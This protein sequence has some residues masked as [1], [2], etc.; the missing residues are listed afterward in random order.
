LEGEYDDRPQEGQSQ[1][2]EE[3]E[4]ENENQQGSLDGDMDVILQH[5]PKE[6]EDKDIGKKEEQFE[7]KTEMKD[8][9]IT[10]EEYGVDKYSW[11]AQSSNDD[12]HSAR[13]DDNALSISNEKE[14]EMK[15]EEMVDEN[16][17]KEEVMEEKEEE[18]EQVGVISGTE[19]F[20]EKE[21]EEEEEMEQDAKGENGSA[22]PPH[23]GEIASPIEPSSPIST[24]L[25][26]DEHSRNELVVLHS[27]K[28][29]LVV[30]D[31][32]YHSVIP[33]AMDLHNNDRFDN[34]KEDAKSE[35]S[36]QEENHDIM[37]HE[38]EKKTIV[39]ET[40]H[41]F[42]PD[43]N[44]RIENPMVNTTIDKSIPN[45][46]DSPDTITET[47]AAS[48]TTTP[49]STS[50]SNLECLQLQQHVQALEK[51]I[52]SQQ[53]TFENELEG[54]QSMLDK[55][56]QQAEM[57]SNSIHQK[58]QEHITALNDQIQ[59]QE[60]YHEKEIGKY[61]TVIENSNASAEKQMNEMRNALEEE[62]KR[63]AKLQ[64]EKSNDKESND[65]KLH[66]AIQKLEDK[67]QEVQLL[68]SKMKDMETTMKENAR[69]ME[70]VEE[71]AD[72][73]HH[74]NE[75]L[76]QRL[77]DTESEIE[78]LKSRIRTLDD[79]REK[80]SGVHMEIQVLKEQHARE[81]E[82]II[83]ESESNTSM[84]SQLANERDAANAKALDLEQQIAALRADLDIVK[85]DYSRA[86]EA[87]HNLQSALEAMQ[88]ESQT[89]ISM[90]EESQKSTEQAIHDAHEA[91]LRAEKDANEKLMAEIQNAA[92]ASVS[93]MIQELNDTETKVE[94]MKKE[95]LNLRRSLDEAIHQLQTNQEDIIDRSLMKNILLDWHSRSGKSRRDVMM[96]MSNV[97]HFTEDEKDKCGVGQDSGNIG[98]ALVGAV[99]PPLAPVGKNFDELE[100][101]TVREK[102]VSFLLS[103]S[104]E[105]DI[106]IDSKNE[107]SN[108]P[109]NS[110]SKIRDATII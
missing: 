38:S 11:N 89:E 34:G 93:R 86:L 73:L 54:Y 14:L 32:N 95:N 1:V 101:D 23:G 70:E 55:A 53:K 102:W 31:E 69:N 5:E 16:K 81:K 13:R 12:L 61:K 60:Q 9:A 78:L 67:D 84:Q 96:L 6:E 71:E 107:L 91:A 29:E 44:S 47:K 50:T 49:T 40:S 20:K 88:S 21:E 100:G 108:R 64:R 17:I 83:A 106:P 99:A 82:R 109:S 80:F 94:T 7:F 3:K 85:S 77:M 58:F 33:N 62:K 35:N 90:L 98:K 18:Q 19:S 22:F 87:N 66:R 8:M 2:K 97:L 37:I 75:A 52:I 25:D 59:T 15:E 105:T 43:T 46:H 42:I 30:K 36:T 92:S 26:H 24:Q 68:K 10:E 103:E 28:D 110:K 45:D 65:K 63:Y 39:E 41:G 48:T 104:G 72:E 74:E 51:Q 4:E 56:N 27:E 57:E 76:Q 79:D